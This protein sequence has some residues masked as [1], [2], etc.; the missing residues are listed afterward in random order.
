MVNLRGDGEMARIY[1]K[2]SH[3]L[4]L[5]LVIL[6]LYAWHTGYIKLGVQQPQQQPQQPQ[7]L[8]AVNKPI[9]FALTDPLG[10]SA[11][12]GASIL[13]YGPDR[14]LRES[15]TT[16]STGIATS[17]LPY[18]SDGQI[19]VKVARSG[20]V[21]RW[22][23]VTVP[24][25]GQADA[26]SLA[27]NFV[28]L[29]TYNLGTYT[30]KVTDQFGNSYSSGGVLNFTALGANTVSVTVTIYNTEDNSGY[31]S[32]FDYLNNIN[33]D[34][35]LL[36]KTSGTSVTVTGAGSSVARGT[37]T[38]WIS[39]LS[40]DQLTRQLVGQ[41][42]VKPG[43]ASVTVTFGRGSL[44]HGATQSFT[45]DLMVYFDQGYFAQ[46]GVGGP[47]AASLASFTLT[48]AA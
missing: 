38:Y 35:V 46:N 3:I 14:V 11:I 37:D 28:A 7:Q 44:A 24:R 10:G 36:A 26:Q 40:G 45:F 32:S 34:A 6:F 31:V 33:L 47:D 48:L 43:V 16:D 29:Q 42:Y 2:G 21:T 4:A 9:R 27:T 25:M 19:Y 1:V 20:Y 15:L 22:I 18:Q 12:G 13:I 8:V 17:A 5:I 23:P 41:Q 30:I 39:V